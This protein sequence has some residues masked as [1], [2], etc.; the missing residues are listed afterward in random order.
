MPM[1]GISERSQT[2]I[3]AFDRTKGLIERVYSAN[4]HPRRFVRAELVLAGRN[5][6]NMNPYPDGTDSK[7]LFGAQNAHSVILIDLLLGAF[8]LDRKWVIEKEDGTVKTLLE[9][10]QG[11]IEG[12]ADF[13]R[14]QGTFWVYNRR[15]SASK[16]AIRVF[17]GF[18]LEPVNIA[19]KLLSVSR[20]S[21][22]S[23]FGVMA[24]SS[25]KCS[26]L[27]ISGDYQMFSSCQETPKFWVEDGSAYLS[28]PPT[29]HIF[30]YF[31]RL[32]RI[33]IREMHNGKFELVD[34]YFDKFVWIE[35]VDVNYL[36]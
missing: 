27:S 16:K 8:D 18:D 33:A 7:R 12:M 25:G 2:A 10:A 24:P 6:S 21:N 22:L 1:T 31:S 26:L 20:D 32:E 23:F 35:R 29:G 34:F 19:S 11:Y 5:F 36:G 15:F 14:T 30:D 28:N 4:A 17:N 13:L 3:G 9:G